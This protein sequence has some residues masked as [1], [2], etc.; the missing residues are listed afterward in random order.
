MKFKICYVLTSCESDNYLEEAYVS[1]YSARHHNPDAHIVLVIDDK[2]NETLKGVRKEE[3]KYADEIKVVSFDPKYN[4]KKRSR[5]LKTMSRD[6]IK[7]DMLYI[8]TDTI[9]AKPLDELD[10]IVTGDLAGVYDLHSCYYR[11]CLTYEFGLIRCQK[12]G[13]EIPEDAHYFN[14]GMT[15]SRDTETAHK[16][17]KLWNEKLLE[18]FD[19]GITTDQQ[20]LFRANYLM[21][22]IIQP[23]DGI[24][25]CQMSSGFQ[26]FLDA[27]I[28]H[29]FGSRSVNAKPLFFMMNKEV[30]NKIKETGVIG[31][32]V[33]EKANNPV[34]GL[35]PCVFTIA[36]DNIK[37]MQTKLYGFFRHRYGTPFFSAVDNFIKL[38]SKIKRTPK[39]LL[40]RG[41][42]D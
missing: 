34:L 26:Y 3:V 13:W 15:F 33:K 41:E 4:A 14:G 28:I 31:D 27:K 40:R 17:Y 30:T 12:M 35:A 36:G 29:Y 10:D 42:R 19:K 22:N 8:D 16:F 6:L 7:G 25:N 38:L 1:M 24:W 39:I 37:F 2:T 32:D 18:C 20:S 23:L 5:L 9:V 21:G 11:D